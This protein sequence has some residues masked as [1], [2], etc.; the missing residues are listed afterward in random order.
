MFRVLR[1][2]QGKSSVKTMGYTVKLSDL[3]KMPQ[4]DSD[5]ILSDLVSSAKARRN[6]QRAI[7]DARIR[8]FEIR[9]EMTSETLHERLRS[10]ACHETA[11][12][13]RWLMLLAAR[14]NRGKQE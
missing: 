7:L 8:D 4:S 1:L 6:G 9:Y 2:V 12:I 14:D 11:E 3:A 10:G 5:Q 13:A